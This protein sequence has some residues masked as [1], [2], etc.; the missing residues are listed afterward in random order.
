[1]DIQDK[2]LK[3]V[4]DGVRADDVATVGQLISSKIFTISTAGGGGNAVFY[5]TDD[6]T[7]TGIK[8]F[9]SIIG[10]QPLFDVADPSLAFSKPVVSNSGRTI[11]INCKKTTSVNLLATDLLTT[12]IGNAPNGVSLTV[13][14][15]GI[16]NI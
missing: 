11:T 3:N 2:Q 9:N 1:M 6:A 16:L 13:L 12:T 15:T 7:S 5:A 10:I 4:S 8:L 14:I